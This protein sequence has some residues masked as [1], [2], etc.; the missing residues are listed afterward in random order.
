MGEKREK[1][2]GFTFHFIR[3]VDMVTRSCGRRNAEASVPQQRHPS[4][5]PSSAAAAAAG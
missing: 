3:E 1:D 4:G 5:Y 2:K